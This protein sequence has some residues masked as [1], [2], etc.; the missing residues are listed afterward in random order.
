MLWIAALLFVSFS[1]PDEEDDML[2]PK[3]LGNFTSLT[4]PL[5]KAGRLFLLEATVDG[6]SGNFILDTGAPGLVLNSTY[7]RNAGISYYKGGGGITGTADAVQKLKVGKL[8]MNDLYFMN[9][10]ADVINLGHIESKL[11]VKVIGLIGVNLL[12]EFELIFD[13]NQSVITLCRLDKSGNRLDPCILN[14]DNGIKHKIKEVNN[15]LVMKAEV[16]EK[17]L[18][19]CLD[20]GAETNVLHIGLPD[21]VINSVQINRRMMLRGSGEQA[22]EVLFGT[23][24]D[25]KIKDSNIKDMGCILTDL[26]HLRELYGIPIGGMLGF[27]FFTQGIICINLEQKEIEI[28]FNWKEGSE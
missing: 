9:I 23:M 11:G 7:F 25:F 1:N 16:G 14:C 15:V 20:T 8:E 12:K 6:K 22:A 27:D 24:Q 4:I 10:F 2:R 13:F 18:A 21:K 26:S 17:N 28:C 5:K 3:P 19:F